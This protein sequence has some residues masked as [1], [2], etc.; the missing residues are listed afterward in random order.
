MTAH[1]DRE[2]PSQTCYLPG[3]LIDLKIY[4]QQLLTDFANNTATLGTLANFA[5]ALNDTT[6]CLRWLLKN[7]NNPIAQTLI[8][9]FTNPEFRTENL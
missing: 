5:T 3:N 2:P 7:P 9:Q 6:T 1:K 8:N 4:P